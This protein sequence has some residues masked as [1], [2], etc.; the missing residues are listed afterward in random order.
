MEELILELSENFT[1][2]IHIDEIKKHPIIYWG[3]NGVG[4]RFA[5]KRFNY[6]V[7]QGNGSLK[8]YSEND[9]E[10]SKEIM[11]DFM[12]ANQIKKGIVGI[13]IHSKRLNITVRPIRKDILDTIKSLQ[14]VVCGSESELVCDHKND[15]YNDERVLRN[16]TQVLDDFQCLCNHCNLLKRQICKK[17]I[18][19]HKLFSAKS[20]PRFKLYD[21][22]FPWEKKVFD[23][24]NPMMKLDTYWYDPIEFDRKL[25]LYEIYIIP[26]LKQIRK[27]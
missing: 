27:I 22:E 18:E 14:C 4:D 21:F 16:E 24:K 5:K 1:K 2:F 12:K 15:L 10:I 13:F 20:L 23:R 26:I 6:S 3:G 19:T 8:T 7:I 17:E 11:D 9:E 25:R